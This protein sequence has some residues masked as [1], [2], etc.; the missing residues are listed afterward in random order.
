MIKSVN[1][2]QP[3]IDFRSVSK[4]IK[5]NDDDE[6][7]ILEDN[8]STR[9]AQ[10][11]QKFESAL[12]DYPVK[13]LSGDVNSNFYEFLSMGII[14]YLAGSA[15]FMVLFNVANKYLDL[16]SKEKAGIV[17]KKLGL[18]VV[19]FGVM[20]E[21][22]KNFVT[23]PVKSATGV[24]INMPYAN[25]VFNLP[26]GDGKNN[27]NDTVWQQRTV[28]D[29][30]EFYRKDLLDKSYFE[31][32]AKKVGLGEDL[33]DPVSETSP[34]IQN[35]VATTKT[36]KSLSSYCWGALGVC[37]AAQDAW[38][39]F[40]KSFTDR[41]RFVKNKDAGFFSNV[42][43]WCKNFGKN[44]WKITG[45]F[46]KSFGKACIELWNGRPNDSGFMKHA[47]KG[48]ILGA[49]A[50]TT[51]LTANAISR[52]KKMARSTNKETIDRTKESTVI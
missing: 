40:F 23:K 50:L 45:E 24:N 42:G 52:A 2:T 8:M 13:G 27:G 26:K 25:K 7:K 14:P 39:G 47:A 10:G 18:G 49:A 4:K 36:A 5:P 20:K 43:N 28:F 6:S 32:V 1:L 22:S 16:F 41:T 48:M 3:N 30:K 31:K 51:V 46:F 19:L 15:M 17:G 44:T 9:M 34:I 11:V 37:L 29:S 21:L 35:I 38:I 33:N 12:V